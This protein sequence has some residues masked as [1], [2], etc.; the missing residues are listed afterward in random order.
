MF[1]KHK[2]ELVGHNITMPKNKVKHLRGIV[3]NGKEQP[4][5]RNYLKKFL[6]LDLEKGHSKNLEKENPE[7]GQHTGKHG[8]HGSKIFHKNFM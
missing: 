1:L 7:R 6:N 5:K 2:E 3:K 4:K 8:K